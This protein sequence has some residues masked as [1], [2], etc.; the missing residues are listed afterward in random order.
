MT[1]KEQ[2]AIDGFH[3]LYY[4]GLNSEGPIYARTYWMNVL[5]LKCPLDLW[6]YQEMIAEMR[7]DLIIETGTHMGGSALFMAHML[8]IV[9]HGE[10]ITIDILDY[11]DRPI[12]PRIK[13]VQGSSSDP[14][15]IHSILDSHPS[16]TRLIILDSDHSKQHVLAEMNLLASYVSIGSY[17]IVEDT[18]INGHPVLPSFGEGGFEAVEDFLNYHQ[19]FEIDQTREKF[20]MTFN[21]RGYLKR[22]R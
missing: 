18:N 15:L 13:Y 19:N 5:C 7:P 10:V 3:D 12:H 11:P 8:D 4:S 22:V 6:I 9:G 20:L 14:E 21:P 17:M 1:P 16:E 2:A